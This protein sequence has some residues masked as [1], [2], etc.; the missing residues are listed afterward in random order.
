[1]RRTTLLHASA[2][3]LAVT[4]TACGDDSDGGGTA[5][6]PASPT[7]TVSV[8]DEPTETSTEAPTESPTDD[9]TD[10]PTDGPTNGV[11]PAYAEFCAA[12]TA[13]GFDEGGYAEI[14]SWALGLDKVDV[15]SDMDADAKAGRK[16][17]LTT[18]KAAKTEKELSKSS[19]SFSQDE[20]DQVQAFIEWINTNCEV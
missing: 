9:P 7:A 18:V 6:E 12:A 8:T 17:M 13:K 5:G 14:R 2:L 11:D 1:M 10:S 3:L 15:P 20:A 19:N 4:L 16:L